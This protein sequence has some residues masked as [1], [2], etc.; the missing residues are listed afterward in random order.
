MKKTIVIAFLGLMS[1]L[2]FSAFAYNGPTETILESVEFEGKISGYSKNESDKVCKLVVQLSEFTNEQHPDGPIKYQHVDYRLYT[3]ATQSEISAKPVWD[4]IV[5]SRI[6]KNNLLQAIPM[7]TGVQTQPS[8]TSSYD[9][10]TLAYK[11]KRGDGLYSGKTELVIN[12]VSPMVF[13]TKPTSVK[14]L[15]RGGTVFPK[16]EADFTCQL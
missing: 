16:T 10:R 13:D 15:M 7:N 8:K 9:G 6:N 3:G 4:A 12:H 5:V 1:V 2:P 11:E 14:V